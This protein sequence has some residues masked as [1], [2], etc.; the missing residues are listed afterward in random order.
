MEVVSKSP[1]PANT[2]AAK[3]SKKAESDEKISVSIRIRPLNS[4]E[5]SDPSAF[6]GI[7]SEKNSITECTK[8]GRLRPKTTLDFD[9]VFGTESST[10]QIFDQVAKGVVSSCMNGIN[11]TIFAYGQTSS[12]KTFTMNGDENGTF[13]GLLPLSGSHI[14][15]TIAGQSDDKE[16]LLRVSFVEIYNEVVTDLFNPAKGPV[17]IRES[18]AKGVYVEAEEKIIGSFE[19]MMATFALGNKNRHVAST[20]MNDRS[21]RSHTI[22]RITVE[23]KKKA[24]PKDDDRRL[25]ESSVES[26]SLE[27]DGAV[28]MGTLSLVD[29]AGS[30]NARNT[31]ASGKTLR[32]GGNINKSLLTLSGV[33]KTLASA[34]GKEVH[35]RFRDSKLTRILQPSL[36][37]NC[38]T[39]VICCVTPA[40]AHLDETRSTLR[41]A[42][43]AKT[44]TTRTSVNEVLDDASMIKRLKKELYM[45]R[46]QKGGV[47]SNDAERMQDENVSLRN[48][49]EKIEK[50]KEEAMSRLQRMKEVAAL[51]IAGGTTSAAPLGVDCTKKTIKKTS[52]RSLRRKK[53]ETWC[54]GENTVTPGMNLLGEK[55][56]TGSAGL[57]GIV[58]D[59]DSEFE[60]EEEETGAIESLGIIRPKEDFLIIKKSRKLT[61]SRR[62]AS[63]GGDVLKQSLAINR[64][65]SHSFAKTTI[66]KKDDKINGLETQLHE[67]EEKRTAEV[68]TLRS[69]IAK[70]QTKEYSLIE[71]LKAM[72]SRA[73]TAEQEIVLLSKTF[74][75]SEKK[76]IEQRAE[77]EKMKVE[78]DV[79]F[80]HEREKAVRNAQAEIAGTK[81]AEIEEINK[82]LSDLTRKFA[83]LENE[84]KSISI[85]LAQEKKDSISKKDLSEKD[86]EIESLSDMLIT[87]NQN[88]DKFKAE[89][90]GLKKEIDSMKFDVST[91]NSFLEKKLEGLDQMKKMVSERRVQAR[92]EI[93]GLVISSQQNNDM[94]ESLKRELQCAKMELSNA[95]DET[96]DIQESLNLALTQ[97][98]EVEDSFATLQSTKNSKIKNL[99][100]ALDNA[101]VRPSTN[102]V[103][104]QVGDPEDSISA[105][106]KEEMNRQIASLEAELKQKSSE[107]QN[108]FKKLD[109]VSAK[110]SAVVSELEEKLQKTEDE[111]KQAL[112]QGKE[113]ESNRKREESANNASGSNYNQADVS[114]EKLNEME[115]KR[116]L[117]EQ[118]NE[119]LNAKI[120][121]L[122]HELATANVSGASASETTSKLQQKFTCL[123]KENKD[124]HFK[125]ESMKTA[126]NK[127]EKK[128]SLLKADIKDATNDKNSLVAEK[129]EML[130]ELQELRGASVNDDDKLNKTLRETE[131]LRQKMQKASNEMGNLGFEK[132]R[133]E[134]ALQT[135]KEVSKVFQSQVEQEQQLK[136]E[137]EDQ[138]ES[139]QFHINELKGTIEVLQEEQ[140]KVNETMEKSVV[141]QSELEENLSQVERLEDDLRA[142][143]DEIQTQKDRIV[144]LERVKMTKQHVENIKKMKRESAKLTA[145]NK[146]LSVKVTSL[147]KM[148]K[149]TQRESECLRESMNG[150]DLDESVR[151]T[152]SDNEKLKEKL[153]KYY[154][155]VQ[156]TKKVHKRILEMPFFETAVRNGEEVMI[157]V[158][159]AKVVA[160]F[161]ASLEKTASVKAMKLKADAQ[162]EGLSKLKERWE[163]MKCSHNNITTEC[164]DKTIEIKRLKSLVKEKETDVCC[165]NEKIS[166]VETL[167]QRNVSAH[168]ES[169]RF[170]EKENLDLM[171]QVKR[172][173]ST[174]N[175]VVQKASETPKS[176][177][178]SKI[179]EKDDKENFLN[180]SNSN[181]PTS[182]A[183]CSGSSK[184]LKRASL[185]SLDDVNT[186]ALGKS[187]TLGDITMSPEDGIA[188]EENPEC[189]QQ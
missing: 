182:A 10:E 65:N 64:R 51:M 122:E 91:Q 126:I 164:E 9:N 11:G 131:E 79:G 184:K 159:A 113:A 177:R 100:R 32:E 41:F 3:K 141:L 83:T 138:L 74:E 149:V 120:Q 20:N 152:I 1:A 89:I 77:Y 26:L 25:S 185:T 133:L 44:L 139:S 103:S 46:K 16:F 134:K 28:L 15:D 69:A 157:E 127:L 82:K 163:Q 128:I 144:K 75:L 5:T 70:Q 40:G 49:N 99:Q 112:L 30:E 84:N 187:M 186:S 160:D 109:V 130:D 106:N 34:K 42:S 72:T 52:S 179:I 115:S 21:S 47:S 135:A 161:T 162:T 78:M 167:L 4:R 43:S 155:T 57:S 116:L 150:L 61:R 38:K 101:Q 23:S 8:T 24:E 35:V 14:F 53:R 168:Q 63:V 154:N 33:I 140:T 165:L 37:G 92:S 146:K 124:I 85:E 145:Q 136:E 66:A 181:H 153:R 7:S 88:S 123:Q 173:K 73:E 125:C 90:D 76:N 98:H 54:P 137:M 143:Q 117:L 22:F 71:Q 80:V 105:E 172:L 170:L 18:R 156:E 62:R 31:G 171:L 56:S 12:G 108:S 95:K 110:N 58:E 102:E 132:L 166:E 13:P 48:Q 67:T 169:V 147:E 174:A 81:N 6:E 180:N 39:A 111:L 148:V 107:L 142:A 119:E 183:K 189:T 178:K 129:M 50:E 2:K 104:V 86:A 118:I 29:L 93:E 36:V 68:E 121:D 87:A 27:L 55:I 19:E 114:E 97:Q 17:R 158:A 151:K 96:C 175:I 60:D 176:E 188:D 45:L 59:D 94:L